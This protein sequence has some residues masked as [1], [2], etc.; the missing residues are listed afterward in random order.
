MKIAQNGE[1]DTAV[2]TQVVKSYI[3]LVLI[4]SLKSMKIAGRDSEV[5]T[6]AEC[7]ACHCS[8]QKTGR[9]LDHL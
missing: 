7:K 3:E 6:E 4:A 1:G 9:W 5:Q 2:K 8:I